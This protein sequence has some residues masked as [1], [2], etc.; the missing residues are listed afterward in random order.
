MLKITGDNRKIGLKFGE[1][2]QKI[3]NYLI[4][5]GKLYYMTKK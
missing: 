2:K 4:I 5:I 1:S 3:D